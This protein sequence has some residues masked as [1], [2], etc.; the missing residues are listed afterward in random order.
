[1][2]TVGQYFVEGF[3]RSDTRTG[4]PGKVGAYH[5]TLST[6]LNTLLAHSF[7]LDRFEEPIT[8]GRQAE[9]RPIWTEVPG[10]LVVRCTKLTAR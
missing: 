8:S 6:Y 7:R 9:L 5:R 3:W 1:V 10:S 2:R 4:P